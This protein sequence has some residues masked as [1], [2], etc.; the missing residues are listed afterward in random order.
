MRSIEPGISRFSGRTVVRRF[1]RPGMTDYPSHHHAQPLR[2]TR[3]TRVEPSGAAF[4]KR[5]ALVEQ[6]HV[7]PLRALRLVHGQ[8]IAI[9]ELVIG[10][11]LFPRDGLDGAAEAV[12]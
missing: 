10:L 6:H 5:K 9:V 11:A 2:G 4:L 12:A 7:V 3:D 1:A 8:H